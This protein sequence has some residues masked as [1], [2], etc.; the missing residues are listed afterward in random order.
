V[1]TGEGEAALAAPK[2]IAAFRQVVR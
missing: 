1:W 2:L